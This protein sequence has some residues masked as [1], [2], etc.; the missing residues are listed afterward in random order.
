VARYGFAGLGV[1]TAGVA[2]TGALLAVIA[3]RV[4]RW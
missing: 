1:L 3:W 4:R 2:G